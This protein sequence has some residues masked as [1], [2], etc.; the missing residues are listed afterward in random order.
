VLTWWFACVPRPTI[1]DTAVIERK[2]V[3]INGAERR[4]VKPT[5]PGLEAVVSIFH[6][7]S[8]DDEWSTWEDRGFTWWPHQY[9]QRVWSEPGF[10]DDGILVY[11]IR[12]ETD[13]V[14]DVTLDAA[15]LQQ[16]D[17]L[18]G[19][20]V[21]SALVASPERRSIKY[22][23]AAWVHSDNVDWLS[24]L[25]A[26]VAAI[27][28]AHGQSQ[29]E[30]LAKTIGGVPDRSSH[31]TTGPRSHPDEMLGIMSVVASVARQP[32]TWTGSL[33]A[34][35]VDSFQTASNVV[36][37]TGDDTAL[38]A[39]LPFGTS[40]SLLTVR[41][42]VAH[43]AIGNG[44]FVRSAF[45]IEETD[46]AWAA[47]MN[48]RELQSTART[49]FLGSWVASGRVPGFVSFY[50]NLLGVGVGEATFNIISSIVGRHRWAAES[51]VNDDW[52]DTDR[53]AEV[54]RFRMTQLGLRPT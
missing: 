39:E 11:R 35:T 21:T 36:H 23:A 1:F 3:K 46:A 5:D 53:I 49:H 18:N 22:A 43:P 28:A 20:A 33:L 54:K 32:S 7:L 41:T 24:R 31:P 8:I 15:A 51:L 17:L 10:D 9:A 30:L 40:T 48:R 42:H 50:P 6:S 27:Q 37:A 25:L 16:L 4:A 14:G 29:G 34:S 45:A 19:Q 26:S 38:T 2:A 52:A 13:V 12:I 44:M 47:E